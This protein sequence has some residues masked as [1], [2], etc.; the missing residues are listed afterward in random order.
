MDEE[1]EQTILEDEIL[2]KLSI[3]CF[4]TTKEP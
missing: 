4:F 1:N 3:N 2:V